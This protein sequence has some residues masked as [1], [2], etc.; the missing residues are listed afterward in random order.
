VFVETQQWRWP[1]VVGVALAAT[2]AWVEAYGV[3]GD[4][5]ALLPA[6]IILAAGTGYVFWQAVLRKHWALLALLAIGPTL[7]SMTFRTRI[8]GDPSL[9]WQVGMKVLAWVGMLTISVFNASRLRR[10]L[11]D[12][13]VVALGCYCVMILSSTAYSPVPLVTALSAIAVVVYL[14][15][16]CVLASEVSER[17]LILVMLWAFCLT[18][19]I[20]V[21]SAFVVPD[22]AYSKS[23]PNAFIRFNKL[24]QD[25][26]LTK[27]DCR[28]LLGSQIIWGDSRRSLHF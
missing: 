21:I 1:I 8:I 10:F 12:P 25:L 15:F 3:G 14:G 23:D 28:A 6:G 17:T 4:I 24:W 7:L 18:C 11:A 20:N 2:L 16:A 22:I 13:V 19:I 9:D 5:T 26:R 27:D